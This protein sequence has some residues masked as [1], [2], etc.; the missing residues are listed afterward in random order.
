MKKFFMIGA[1]AVFACAARAENPTNI[2][3]NAVPI[4]AR[5][6]FLNNCA[7]CHSADASGDEGP[8]LHRL[9]LTNA[10]ITARIQ[11]GKKGQMTAF[12]G[13]LTPGEIS[14]LVLYLRT[15]K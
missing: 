8:D 1:L 14:A 7:H 3:T 2:S 11:N 9:D 6:L 13:K 10:Q 15:L 12:A 4:A 5:K